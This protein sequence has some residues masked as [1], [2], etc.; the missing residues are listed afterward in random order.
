MEHLKDSQKDKWKSKET[1]A[2]VLLLFN[3]CFLVEERTSL[4]TVVAVCRCFPRLPCRMSFFSVFSRSLSLCVFGS[5]YLG[6]LVPWPL[7]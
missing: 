1:I 6:P 2:R 4:V 7:C 5:L 3:S